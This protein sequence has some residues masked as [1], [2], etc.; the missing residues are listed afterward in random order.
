MTEEE[1]NKIGPEPAAQYVP[2]PSAVAGKPNELGKTLQEWWDSDS[3]KKLQKSHQESI[4]RA[5]GKYY[6][7]SAEDKYDMVQAL[8]YII[9][10][11]EREGT[12][13]RGLMDTLGIYPEGFWIDDLMTVH[14]AL[15][16]EFESVTKD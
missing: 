3:C 13:H 14:N 16:T 8:C 7:L 6:M 11:A 2:K 5:V 12:S 9:C 10:K 4:Q 1:A 15:F